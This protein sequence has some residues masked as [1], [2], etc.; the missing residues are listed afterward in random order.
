ME[1]KKPIEDLYSRPEIVTLMHVF[2]M[3]NLTILGDIIHRGLC[4]L[5]GGSSNNNKM[6]LVVTT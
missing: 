6:G 3:D 5:G 2:I 1:I 4:P